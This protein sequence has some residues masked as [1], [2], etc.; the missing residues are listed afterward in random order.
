[1]PPDG[2]RRIEMPPD[3]VPQAGEELVRLVTSFATT[4]EE[5]AR[6]ASVLDD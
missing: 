6:F 5:I 4:S 2:V 1:M 3:G